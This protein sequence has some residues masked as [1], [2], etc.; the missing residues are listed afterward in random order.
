MLTGPLLFVRY[1]FM[2]NHLGYC[3]GDDSRTM[4]EYAV[5]AEEDDGLRQLERQFE[6]AYPYLQLIAMTNNIA[7]PLD[8]RVVE[9]YWVGNE[10]LE[11]I[12]Q[13]QFYRH[14]REGLRLK[15]RLGGKAFDRLTAKI[16]QGAVPH[17]SFHV[18][19]IW[20]R[21]GHEER[22]HTL[23]SIDSCRVS[24]GTV[25]EINGPRITVKS[26]PLIYENRKLHLGEAAL[27]PI[28]R[29]LEQ[30][31][32]LD[33]LK[34]GDLITIHWGVICEVINRRQLNHLR[35]YTLRHLALANQT[36]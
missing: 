7:D 6:G 18:L 19:D 30:E 1:A 21:T 11:N 28:N 4:F 20:K 15:D 16:E 23:E 13:K 3:G 22:E 35:R 34:I 26:E 33:Q 36:I 2:P 5:N 29:R 12:S 27:R 31:P 24:W 14:L 25:Q 17:H 8:A 10:L 9:A 32:D